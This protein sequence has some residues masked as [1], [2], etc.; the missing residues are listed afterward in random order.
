MATGSAHG[1]TESPAPQFPIGT[2][3]DRETLRREQERTLRTP[4]RR[5]SV[6]ARFLF[7]FLD[8]VYGSEWTLAKLKV[9]ELVARVPYQAWENV[10]YIAVTHTHGEPRFA[11]RIFDRISEAREQQDNEQW[12]LLILEELLHREPRYRD[13]VRYV[14]TPQ[15]L[16][17]AY[18]HLSWLLFVVRPRWSYRLNAD[19]EDHAEH[20]Y[21][22]FVRDNPE[23]EDEPYDGEFGEE[24]GRF[25]TLGDLF[26][27]VSLDERTHK[28][29]SVAH[30]RDARFR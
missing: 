28:Q 16:A 19:L 21:A 12:H 13:P 24:Y 27:R 30:L 5:Y 4:R 11:R 1:V 7:R 25:A 29:E 26:R 14:V 22:A 15:L 8:L 10:A 9:L 2:Q 3:L 17:F 18:Y 23:L 20:Q 6:A